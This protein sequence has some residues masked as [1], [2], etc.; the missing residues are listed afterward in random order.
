M[1]VVGFN[2]PPGCG[3]DT[4]AWMLADYMDTKGVSVPVYTFPL[5][6]P[7]RELAFKMVGREYS[8]ATYED[9]KNE[10]FTQFGGVN[11][12][13]LMIDVSEK[14]LKQVYGQTIMAR[15][16]ASRLPITGPCVV[17]V[18]DCGFQVEVDVITAMFGAENFYLARVN[19]PGCDFSGDSRGPVHHT[20]DTDI[21]N[22]GTLDELKVEAGRIYGRLVNKMGWTL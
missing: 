9:F 5:S 1:Y 14:F 17:L 4:L 8:A 3:K 20:F 11:G 21:N 2:G 18:P 16:W 13:Q 7:L 6:H 19:R 22:S 12:R 15:I 10:F